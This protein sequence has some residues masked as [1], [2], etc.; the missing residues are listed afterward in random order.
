MPTYT[1]KCKA[2]DAVYD[3]FNSMSNRKEGGECKECDSSDTTQQLNAALGISG[4]CTDRQIRTSN[5][6]GSSK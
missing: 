4:C 3:R 5:P 2:C 6:K 1:Y